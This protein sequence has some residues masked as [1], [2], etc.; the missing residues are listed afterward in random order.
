MMNTTRYFCGDGRCDMTRDGKLLYRDPNHLNM[1]GS[2][3]L[4]QRMLDDNPDF[5]AAVTEPERSLAQS[6]PV[7]IPWGV[8]SVEQLHS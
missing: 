7:E 4:A 1:N 2:R 8:A 3:F 6:Q 5:R